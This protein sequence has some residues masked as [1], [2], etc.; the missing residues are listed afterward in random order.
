MPRHNPNLDE[1][2]SRVEAAQ[3]RLARHERLSRIALLLTLLLAI[4]LLASVVSHLQY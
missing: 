3:A 4:G 1:Q 2:S